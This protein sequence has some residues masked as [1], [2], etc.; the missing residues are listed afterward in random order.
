MCFVCLNFHLNMKSAYVHLCYS[1][2]VQVQYT[3]IVAGKSVA[4]NA[5]T[6]SKQGKLCLICVPN[7]FTKIQDITFDLGNQTVYSNS[8]TTLPRPW[9]HVTAQ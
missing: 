7:H 9:E 1:N 8:I 6:L 5:S 2:L 4:F 3:R